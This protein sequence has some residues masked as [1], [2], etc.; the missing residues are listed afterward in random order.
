MEAGFNTLVEAGYQPEIAYFECVHEMKLI[1]DLIYEGG[2][3]KMRHSIS[4]TAEFGDYR[5]GCRIVTG[6]TRTERKRGLENIQSGEF[7]QDFLMDNEMGQPGRAAGRRKTEG[8][9]S[10]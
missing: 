5:T 8:R 2:F 3:E 10:A 9:G 4:N 1:V 6:Q 7:A